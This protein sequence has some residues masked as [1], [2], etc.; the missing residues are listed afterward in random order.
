MGP[1]KVGWGG[2]HTGRREIVDRDV[3]LFAS[4]EEVAFASLKRT[5]PKKGGLRYQ[6]LFEAASDD[7]SPGTACSGLGCRRAR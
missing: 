1:Y 4:R 6:F 7:V 3:S 5:L 2:S